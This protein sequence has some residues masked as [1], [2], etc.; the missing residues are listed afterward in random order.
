MRQTVYVLSLLHFCGIK[1][2]VILI[3]L[4]RNVFFS[5]KQQHLHESYKK[6]IDIWLCCVCWK[7]T[8]DEEV[9]GPRTAQSK[10][11]SL[12]SITVYYT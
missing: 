4:E 9:F 5:G 2:L 1:Q 6:M 8:A 3:E 12:N 10:L 7:Q 11:N